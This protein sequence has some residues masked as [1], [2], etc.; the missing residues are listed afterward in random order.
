M[1]SESASST[2]SEGAELCNRH[3]TL[4]GGHA[5]L[6]LF[7]KIVV[8]GFFFSFCHAASAQS[9]GFQIVTS[10]GQAAEALFIELT[11]DRNA[12]VVFIP[13]AASSLRSQNK[14]IWDPDKEENKNEFRDEMLKRFKIDRITILHTRDRKVANSDEFVK[15]LREATAVWISGGNP[16]RFTSTYLGTKVERN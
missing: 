9:T 6:M 7:S 11:S 10:G 16:G 5:F 2:P 12:K 8:I 1:S 13:T 14:V 4:R 3:P 15:P